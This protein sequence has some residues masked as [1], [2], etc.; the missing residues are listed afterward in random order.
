MGV[1]SIG[2]GFGWKQFH[3]EC[4]LW[5]LNRRDPWKDRHTFDPMAQFA[6]A[7]GTARPWLRLYFMAEGSHDLSN[8]VYLSEWACHKNCPKVAIAL[9][10][11]AGCF[12]GVISARLSMNFGALIP[13]G[14]MFRSNFGP[15]EVYPA[16]PCV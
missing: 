14:A 5:K 2:P 1:H 8:T 4:D 16:N 15:L 12:S 9:R 3:A 13:I 6:M 10:M 7:A 11:G